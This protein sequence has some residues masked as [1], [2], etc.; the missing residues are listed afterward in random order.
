MT[1][2]DFVVRLAHYLRSVDRETCGENDV[3]EFALMSIV[4]AAALAFYMKTEPTVI[5]CN[6]AE[7]YEQVACNVQ[8]V[9]DEL[10]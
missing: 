6:A 9:L 10:P 4:N 7:R 3:H 8:C 1:K 5:C 2:S